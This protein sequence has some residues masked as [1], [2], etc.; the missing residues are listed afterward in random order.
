MVFSYR[1]GTSRKLTFVAIAALAILVWM[2]LVVL[3]GGQAEDYTTYGTLGTTML[4]ILAA[5]AWVW[6]RTRTGGR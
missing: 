1:S 3:E 2:P 6:F 4:L 5:L